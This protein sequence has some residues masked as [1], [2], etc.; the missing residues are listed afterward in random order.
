ME[1]LL[2]RKA[3]NLGILFLVL[4][5]DS[6]FQPV[7]GIRHLL[8]HFWAH[9][10]NCMLGA[11]PSLSVCLFVCY[12]MDSLMWC[13]KC[14]LKHSSPPIDDTRSQGSQGSRSNKGPK[15]RQIG[16]HQCQVASLIIVELSVNASGNQMYCQVPGKQGL[17]QKPPPMHGHR[18]PLAWLKG[19]LFNI[20]LDSTSNKSLTYRLH[21]KW[22]Y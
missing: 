11:Y 22:K 8:A 2:V 18:S 5:K 6:T 13:N 16:S 17:H 4:Y 10:C 14:N 9:L 21:P 20:K 19:G 1:D 15:Q 3:S 7:G 12:P